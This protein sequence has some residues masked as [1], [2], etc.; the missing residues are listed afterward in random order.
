MHWI[1]EQDY[2]NVM[3]KEVEPYVFSRKKSGFDVR[4]EGQPIYYEHFKADNPKAVIVIS[5]GFTES[6]QKFTESIFYMLQEG[7]EVWGFDHRGHGHSF[8]QNDNPFVVHVDHFKDYVLDLE[9]LVRQKVKP[10]AG[11]L[12]VYLYCHSMGGCVGAW[13]IETCPNLFDKAV[14]SS[15]MLG[16]SFGKIPVPL[17][18]AGAE[19]KCIG[20]KRTQSLS[21]VN[22]FEQEDF[23]NSCDSSVSRYRYYYKKRLNDTKLQTRSPSIGWGMESAK[24]CARVT[25]PF[26]TSK[27]K[28]PVLLCQAGNETVVKNSSQ[29]KFVSRVRNCEFFRVPNMKHELYMA[30]TDMLVQY[31]QRIFTFFEQKKTGEM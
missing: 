24:A 12:P 29:N 13:I 14:L 1:T 22:E 25:S 20:G 10:A 23:E 2:E 4:I 28:I 5:H 6:V 26:W 27:I 19:L 21:P 16:L 17:V 31:W 11:K 9:H 18:Y 3:H 8:R 7:Y 15:P 30:D